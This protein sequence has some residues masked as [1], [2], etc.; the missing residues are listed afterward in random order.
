MRVYSRQPD[1][2]TARLLFFEQQKPLLL[3]NA[4]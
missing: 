2:K 3:P 4:G 1:K